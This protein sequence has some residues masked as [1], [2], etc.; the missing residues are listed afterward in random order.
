VGIDSGLHATIG[1][2]V[3]FL[4]PALCVTRLSTQIHC[5]DNRKVL[6]KP[7]GIIPAGTGNGLAKS[8]YGVVDPAVATAAVAKAVTIATDLVAIRQRENGVVRTFWSFLMMTWG[9]LSDI[10]IESEQFR[11]MGDNRFVV[12]SAALVC[13]RVHTVCVCAVCIFATQS[14]L[15]KIAHAKKYQC[16]IAYRV[17]IIPK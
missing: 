11:W 7:I 10:D 12:V 15:Q 13:D 3:R 16:R 8:L 6:E 2:E 14:A 4:N 5:H 1:L 9:L 17:P